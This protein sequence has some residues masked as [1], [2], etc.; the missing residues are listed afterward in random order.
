MKCLIFLSVQTDSGL[1]NSLDPDEM[2]HLSLH[3]D[4]GLANS[5]DPDEMPHDVAFHLG[6]HCLTKWAFRSH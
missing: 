5:V 4:S 1:A 6:L 2:P 3:I